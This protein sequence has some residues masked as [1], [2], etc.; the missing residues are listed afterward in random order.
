MLTREQ[1]HTAMVELDAT[2]REQTKYRP[3]LMRQMIHD[4]GGYTTAIRL[5]DRLHPTEGFSQ[6]VMLERKDL[7]IEALVVDE[8]W[9]PLFESRLVEIAKRRL[10]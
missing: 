3:N 5:V 8:R 2:I 10:R 7:T 1:F 9:S 4:V 6:M